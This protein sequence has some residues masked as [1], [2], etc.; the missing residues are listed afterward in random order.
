MHSKKIIS[1]QVNNVPSPRPQPKPSPKIKIFT[2][3]F[4]VFLGFLGTGIFG[5]LYIREAGK[6]ARRDFDRSDR[7]LSNQEARWL[8]Q[9]FKECHLSPP[10]QG[11]FDAKNLL[12]LLGIINK[13]YLHQIAYLRYQNSSDKTLSPVFLGKDIS[14]DESI[15]FK[16][17]E[18]GIPLARQPRFYAYAIRNAGDKTTQ[19]PLIYKKYLWNSVPDLLR[20]AGFGGIH[21]EINRAKAIHGFVMRYFQFDNAVIENG[22]EDD[23]LKYFAHYGYGV[24]DDAARAEAALMGLAGMRS[25]IWWLSGHVVPETFAGGAWRLFDPAYKIYFHSK[26]DA[27]KIYGVSELAARRER[28][29]HY[30]SGLWGEGGSYPETYKDFFQSTCDNKVVRHTPLTNG[31]GVDCKLR[32]GEKIVFTNFNWGK[33]YMSIF[34]S[35]P[36]TRYYNGYFEYPANIADMRTDKDVV[37]LSSG[38]VLELLNKSREESGYVKINFT[39]PFPIVGGD[40]RT[41]INKKAGSAYIIIFGQYGKKAMTFDLTEGKNFLDWSNGL[42]TLQPAPLFN[43]TLGIKLLPGSRIGVSGLSIRTEFQFGKLAL[44]DLQKGDNR[45]HTYFTD[46]PPNQF[47]G[48]VFIKY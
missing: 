31:A 30:V 12:P 14:Y 22:V 6:G 13:K 17:G 48:E 39:S 37:I 34:Y 19:A 32:R 2:V 10:G 27:R 47:E 44:L 40:I 24:C 23:P 21:D 11:T 29:D 20:T 41:A 33:H 38:P 9:A 36:L 4:A 1:Q 15:R 26:G 35:S 16:L 25:R 5:A 18:S 28:F 42:D 7:A 43:Y 46:A 3:Y 8:R 45:F